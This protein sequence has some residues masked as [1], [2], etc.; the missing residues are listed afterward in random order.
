MAK[1]LNFV[2]NTKKNGWTTVG[3]EGVKKAQLVKVGKSY[4]RRVE[5]PLQVF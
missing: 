4:K 3:Q 1:P 5:A 2:K